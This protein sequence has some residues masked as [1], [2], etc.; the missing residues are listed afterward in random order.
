[1]EK[2]TIKELKNYLCCDNRVSVCYKGT[3]DFINFRYIDDVP[4][5]FDDLC[6]DFLDIRN[7]EFP[8]LIEGRKS[9]PCM[10]IIVSVE[11]QQMIQT[12]SDLEYECELKND[13][14]ILYV[15]YIGFVEITLEL[16][17][18]TK[19]IKKYVNDYM[20]K[21]E[22]APDDI[23]ITLMNKLIDDNI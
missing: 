8:D 22:I 20:K 11:V 4:K 19:E 17:V 10:E 14:K 13:Q 18:Q 6:V 1:M 16:D 12:L 9:F 3:Y 15:R 7:R 23:E 21:V 2:L 5:I